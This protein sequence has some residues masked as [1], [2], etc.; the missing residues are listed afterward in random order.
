M[1]G[2]F[3]VQNLNYHKR[4]CISRTF[5]H[6]IEAKR[7]GCGL[8]M[9][10]SVFGVLKVPRKKHKRNWQRVA[11]VRWLF[12]S[13]VAA[14]GIFKCLSANLALQ[15]FFHAINFR[16]NKTATYSKRLQPVTAKHIFPQRAIK[17]H[18]IHEYSRGKWPTVLLFFTT[19]MANSSTELSV[20]C[21]GLSF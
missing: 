4:P 6:K 7:R 12:Y 14:K 2:I 17:Y 5:F 9:D 16:F 13:V 20:S 18:K 10:T 11:V 8:S 21:S 19:F 3:L 1:K 15:K